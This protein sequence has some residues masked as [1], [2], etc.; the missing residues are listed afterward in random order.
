MSAPVASETRSPFRASSGSA[1]REQG[2][3][4]DSAP[5]SELAQVQRVSL[6]GQA[7]VPSQE[8]GKGKPFGVG[9]G[10]LN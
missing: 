7:A 6:P 9:E 1:N 5:G 10:R 4:P 2:Q 3:G 8:P